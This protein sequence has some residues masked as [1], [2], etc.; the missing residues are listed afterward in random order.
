MAIDTFLKKIKKAREQYDDA[1]SALSREKIA[2]AIGGILPEGF[3]LTWRQYTPGFNDGEPCR[4]TVT[5][6]CIATTMCVDDVDGKLVLGDEPRE[7]WDE[8]DDGVVDLDYGKA[9]DLKW[10]GL[11]SAGFKSVEDAWE[12]IS[13]RAFLEHT[14][15]DGVRVV[16]HH[17]GDHVVE[18]YDCGY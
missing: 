15:G 9:S 18:G 4:F 8:G 11:T 3:S 16:I 2:E 14:F 6:A 1:L 10:A 17:G 7:D 12:Q 5:S 13:D